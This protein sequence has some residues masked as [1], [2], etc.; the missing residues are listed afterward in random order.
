[1]SRVGTLKDI[2]KETEH[3]LRI[4]LRRVSLDRTFAD[5]MPDQFSLALDYLGPIIVTDQIDVF[6]MHPSV[7]ISLLSTG[8][9]HRLL[10]DDITT[11]NLLRLVDM[12]PLRSDKEIIHSKES[13]YLKGNGIFLEI[14]LPS[15]KIAIRQM[16]ISK[17][18]RKIP[19]IPK[20]KPEEEIQEIP[21][22]RELV[23]P[24]K[25]E[26]GIDIMTKEDQDILRYLEDYERKLR[27]ARR[28]R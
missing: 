21:S 16:Q 9:V 23:Q 5:S 14:L 25:K 11:V 28:D 22:K 2:K 8:M 17:F 15:L 13:N 12:I 20:V 7:Y 6:Y 24:S 27:K 4:L 19:E 18:L 10:K 26:P 3:V 1:M